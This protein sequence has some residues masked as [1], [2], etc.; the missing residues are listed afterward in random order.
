MNSAA[1]SYTD[2]VR[3][4]LPVDRAYIFGS[5]AKKTATECSDVDVCFFLQNFGGKRRVDIIKELLKLTN[6]YDDVGFEPL[7]F[8]SS[9]LENGNPFVKE[10]LRTG[11]EI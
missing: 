8:P 6:G 4:V 1:K 5:H 7:A 3:S 2:S 9:E 11:R 10:I